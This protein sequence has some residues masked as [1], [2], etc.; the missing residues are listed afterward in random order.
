MADFTHIKQE[1]AKALESILG[2]LIFGSGQ[3]EPKFLMALNDVCRDVDA[4]R[5]EQ[6]LQETPRIL[7]NN[8][9]TIK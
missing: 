9:I 2:G 4:L 8:F 3:S 7:K 5:E 6:A 1:Q